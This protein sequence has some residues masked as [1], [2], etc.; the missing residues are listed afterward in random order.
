MII[1]DE[2]VVTLKL[3]KY[4]S[5]ELADYYRDSVS[6][7]LAALQEVVRDDDRFKHLVIE[8]DPDERQTPQ[9]SE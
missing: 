2:Y 9:E 7:A 5:D 6:E 4:V 8:V 1:L 3:K